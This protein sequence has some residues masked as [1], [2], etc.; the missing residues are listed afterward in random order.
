MSQAKSTA[1]LVLL[2]AILLLLLVQTFRV[3]PKPTR[4][5]YFFLN[6]NDVMLPDQILKFEKEG[7]EFVSATPTREDE[8][9]AVLRRAK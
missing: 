2:F 3:E 7:W 6:G 9:V 4:Y 5:E 1:I 8:L